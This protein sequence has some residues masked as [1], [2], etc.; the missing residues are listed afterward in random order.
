MAEGFARQE[1]IL[2]ANP[3]TFPVRLGIGPPPTKELHMFDHRHLRVLPD[4][5]PSRRVFVATGLASGLALAVQPA[6]NDHQWKS[7]SA[8][9]ATS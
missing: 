8:R 3:L 1:K 7:S 5:E 6:S 4:L 2:A 9:I